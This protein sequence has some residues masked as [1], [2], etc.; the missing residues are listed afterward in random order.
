MIF[1]KKYDNS[2]MLNKNDLICSQ[3]SNEFQ[4][5]GFGILESLEK[6]FAIWILPNNE[7][8]STSPF[9][10]QCGAKFNTDEKDISYGCY[11]HDSF[12][13]FLYKSY[14]VIENRINAYKKCKRIQDRI[15]ILSNLNDIQLIE[16]KFK[17]DNLSQFS[18]LVYRTKYSTIWVRP[19]LKY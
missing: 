16:E 4:K 11:G 7:I 17:L 19:S 3:L 6:E 13:S 18:R 14:H 12:S 2:I 1:L 5:K 9:C 10:K 15:F 8:I